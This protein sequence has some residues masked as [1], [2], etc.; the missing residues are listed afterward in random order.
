MSRSTRWKLLAAVLVA[1]ALPFPS[2]ARYAPVARGFYAVVFEQV[3][4]VPSGGMLVLFGSVVYLVI[5]SAIVYGLLSGGGA[6][7]RRARR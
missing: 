6:L 1:L 4:D 5:Y 2:S 7:V 3:G